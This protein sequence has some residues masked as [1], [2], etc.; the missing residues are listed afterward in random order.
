L[1]IRDVVAR[2]R[3]VAYAAHEG[4]VDKT[5]KPYI[6]HPQRVVG[7]LDDP[8]EQ[9]VAWLH[10]VVEDTAVTLDDLR[11]TFPGVIVDAVDAMTKRPGE[12]LGDYIARVRADPIATAVKRADVADN[13]SLER[14]EYLDEKTRDRLAR[15]YVR[16]LGLLDRA[17]S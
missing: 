2:A 13:S 17:T 14:L 9:A 3:D 6:A 11:G 15:K 10:D 4:Q 16:T 12:P 8:T 1:S 7:R 5:G